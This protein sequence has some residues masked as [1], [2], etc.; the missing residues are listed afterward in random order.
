MTPACTCRGC[1]AIDRMV[2]PPSLPATTVAV[3]REAALCAM[4]AAE[5][6]DAYDDDL[7][8]DLAARAHEWLSLAIADLR[9]AQGGP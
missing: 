8:L 5:R 4:R 1:A 7:A 2:Q 3:L 6:T 9:A